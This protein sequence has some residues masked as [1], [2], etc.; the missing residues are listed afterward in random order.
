[1]STQKF[2]KELTVM[3]ESNGF[4][5]QRSSTHL[6]WKHVSG[7]Q[8]FTSATPSCRHALNQIKRQIR[9]KGVKIN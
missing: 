2:K 6:V 9:Q 4:E 1:M 3:M 8:I 5:L 7:V